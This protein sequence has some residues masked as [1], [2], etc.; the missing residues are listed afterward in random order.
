[1]IERAI[2]SQPEAGRDLLVNQWGEVAMVVDLGVGPEALR[3]WVRVVREQERR[4]YTAAA[5]ANVALEALPGFSEGD[6]DENGDA[7]PVA[8]Y[9]MPV[10]S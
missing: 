6:V 2:V 7:F 3:L 4:H 9:P 5:R 1:M 10:A 8:A